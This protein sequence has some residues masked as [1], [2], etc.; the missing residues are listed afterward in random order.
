M[1]DARNILQFWF[2][3]LP[4]TRSQL[5]E[6]MPFWFGSDEPEELHVLTDQEIATRFATDVQRALTGQL[7]GWA[8]S[9]RRRLALILLLDQFPRNIYRGTAAAFSGDS[10]A[11]PLAIEGLQHGADATL[12][13]IER[14]FF[15]MPLQHAESREIQDESVAAFRRLADEAPPQLH[16]TFQ[17]VLRFAEKHRDIIQ[18][19]GRFPHRNEILNRPSTSNETEY[20]RRGAPSFGATVHSRNTS[21][22]GNTSK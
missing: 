6:R 22:H 19:F 14:I 12:D 11:M 13:P 4:T 10:K 5:Q 7:N 17:D 21:H 2:G 8:D 9:P 16:G 18:E 15:Y 3:T 1:N 20:L